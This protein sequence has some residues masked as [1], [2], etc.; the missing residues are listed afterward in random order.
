VR[1][2]DSGSDDLMIL[3]AWVEPH[4]GLSLRV[5]IVQM[6]MDD[7]GPPVTSA[8][9][10]VEDACSAVRS[11]LEQLLARQESGPPPSQCH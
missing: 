10:T 5:R 7:T 4:H 8:A 1:T 11:W 3:R 9:A 6:S 2:I